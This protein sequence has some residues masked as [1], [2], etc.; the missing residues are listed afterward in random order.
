MK[1]A[2][3]TAPSVEPIS[4]TEAKLHLR[5]ATTTAEAESYTTEDAQLTAWIETAR[6]MAEAETGTRLITQSWYLYLDGWPDGDEMRLPYPPLQSATVKYRLVDD[7]GYD[8]TF[9]DVIVDIASRPGRIVL[10]SDK[11]WPMGTLYDVNPIQIDYTCGYGGE[12]SDVPGKLRSAMLL[13][14]T[15]LYEH[16]GEI[17]IGASVG[18]LHDAAESLLRQ[19]RDWTFTA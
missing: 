7:S 10:K 9:S 15:D 17:V 4:L 13:K 6:E 8:N 18:R 19:C 11:S 5:L 16:R 1:L 2:L 3:K 12:G 14:L